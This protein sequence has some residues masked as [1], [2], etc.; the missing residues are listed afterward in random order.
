M[1]AERDHIET[2]LVGQLDLIEQIADSEALVDA[3]AGGGIGHRITKVVEANLHD[4]DNATR[5]TDSPITQLR[6]F[7]ARAQNV[8]LRFAS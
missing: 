1:L 4:D 8:R 3:S 6:T 7:W 5:P 2:N